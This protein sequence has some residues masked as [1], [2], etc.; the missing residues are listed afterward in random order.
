MKEF[1]RD[2]EHKPDSEYL[3]VE[4]G[5]IPELPPWHLQATSSSRYPFPTEQAAFRFANNVK[6]EYPNRDVAVLTIDGERF[7]L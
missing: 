3:W 5:V 2:I 7:V 1:R 4:L 6:A